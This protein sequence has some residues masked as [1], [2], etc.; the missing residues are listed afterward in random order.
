[1]RANCITS[2]MA[3]ILLAAC[4]AA[5][6]PKE[7][8][9]AQPAAARP[10]RVVI[11][12][13][14]HLKVKLERLGFAAEPSH[15]RERLAPVYRG[16]KSDH[17]PVVV[18]TDAA[19]HTWHLYFDWYLRFLEI[20]H[21]RGDLINLSDALTV[22]V[23]E[24]HDAAKDDEGKGAAMM[25]ASYLLVGKRLLAGGDTAGAPEPWKGKIEKELELIAEAKGIAVS[26][27]FGVPEDYSQYKPRGHYSRS[28]EFATY[29]RAMMWFGRMT[30][31]L[32][33]PETPE[34]AVKHTRCAMVI[35]EALG[36]CK[37][38]GE[39]AAAVWERIY[40]T[41]AFFAGESDDLLPSDYAALMDKHKG[42]VKGFM[43]AARKLRKPRVLGTYAASRITAGGPQWQG[44]T[45]GMTLLG[46]RYSLDGEIMQ[47]LTFDSVLA[48]TG[49]PKGKL[50]FTC[51]NAR[52]A[53]IRG[54]PRGLDV[55][56]ALGSRRAGAL[57]HQTG[58]DQ[59][60]NYEKHLAAL[61]AQIEKLSEKQ[62]ASDL[63]MYRLRA[64]LEMSIK[65]KGALPK[66]MHTDEWAL[67]ELT[68]ALGS[69]AEL[70]HDTILYTKQPYA[71]AQMALAGGGKGV[72]EPPPPPPPRGYVEP[73]PHVYAV[74]GASA[75]VLSAHIKKLGYP[76]D[77]ALS[78]GVERF[79]GV[80]DT[81]KALS[82][83][84][85]AGKPLTDD[86]FSFIENIGRVLAIPKYGLPHHRDVTEEF[87]TE[88]DDMMP[89]VADVY[90][91][92]NSQQVL[93]QAVG[94]PMTI[95]MVC[96]VN[97][98]DTVCIGALY[99]YYEFKRP[100]DKRMTDEEWREM[101]R[102]GDE[103]PMAEW[104]MTYAVEKPE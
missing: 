56:A 4:A 68:A 88:M 72:P 53:L 81:L 41:T 57:I 98:K 104:T 78:S 46:Q 31:R 71:M 55:M 103:P 23:L 60:V 36:D 9:Q 16:W 87:M 102:D 44:A 37:V 77:M 21:L 42:D 92:V 79:I 8:A 76:K 95:Y 22:K 17:Y 51:V 13:P 26:P 67:K 11:K 74:V 64:A 33:T 25:A 61:K 101:L 54:F 75:R 30:F 6:E 2:A 20:A 49:K 40:K 85:L 69:W 28:K 83:K 18:T 12:V 52:G 35:C 3:L 70:K 91:D 43:A 93:E 39:D 62:W 19:L 5:A 47:R 66:A 1:M 63:Y 86:E 90:T 80:M 32:S 73:M 15:W 96:P 10:P 58:D 97:G 14:D 50:P 89:I 82:E 27:L 7:P 100:M 45:Q 34:L 94:R 48:Y 59:Y 84:E 99:S 38:K 24:L 29:F 65:P